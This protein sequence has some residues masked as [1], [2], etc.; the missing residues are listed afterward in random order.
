M[1]ARNLKYPLFVLQRVLLLFLIYLFFQSSVYANPDLTLVGYVMPEDGLGKIPINIIDTLDGDISMNIIHTRAYFPRIEHPLSQKVLTALNNSDN[2]HGKVAIFTEAIRYISNPFFMHLPKESIIKIAYSMFETD[3]VPPSWREILNQKFDAVVVPDKNLKSVYENS[4]IT[5]PI[6]VLPIPMNLSMYYDHPSHPKYPFVPYIN[7]NTKSAPLHVMMRT[8][9]TTFKKK[10]SLTKS[11]LFLFP[12]TNE[13]N[14]PFVFGDS[15][16]KKN[17]ETLVKAFAIAFGNHP[18]VQLHM[19]AIGFDQ[20]TINLI[21][22]IMEQYHLTNVKIDSERISL[23]QFID[24]LSSYDCYVN[25]SRGEGFSFIQREALALGIP[26]ISTNNTSLT[27]V[28]QSGN[29]RVVASNK[30]GP[31]LECYK[32]IFGDESIGNQFDCEVVDVVA[33]LLDVFENYS[34]YLE[35]ARKGRGWVN[36]YDCKN[37]KLRQDY[38]TLVKPSKIAL[39]DKNEIINGVLITSSIELFQKY[40]QIMFPH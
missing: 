3:T 28:C 21:E 24:R 18:H 5:I 34:K 10:S 16:A 12:Q 8:L 4:G 38:R 39:G 14:K 35:K 23:H 13:L 7:Q 11:P 9:S 33:A 26:V 30:L 31:A 37:P 17:P 1:A 27:T 19:R 22:G 15:S 6:F 25:L 2:T 29:V 36:Q 40:L 20:A 32:Y